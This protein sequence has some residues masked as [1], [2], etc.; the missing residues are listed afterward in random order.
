MDDILDML[1]QAIDETSFPYI[2]P[3][4]EHRREVHCAEQHLQWLEEHLNEE[5][6]VHLEALRNAELYISTLE[7]RASVRVALAVGVRLALS[8]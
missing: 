1:I 6:R 2:S 8:S 3:I 7:C 5:E 4:G